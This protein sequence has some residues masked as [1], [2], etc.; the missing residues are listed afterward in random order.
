MLFENSLLLLLIIKFT[1]SPP[2]YLQ[3]SKLT[4]FIQLKSPQG[5]SKKVF[6]EYFFITLGMIFLVDKVFL[7]EEPSP[8]FDSEPP[9]LFFL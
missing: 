3:S 7:F 1:I 4:S 9:H 2:I 6:I 5:A 8:D